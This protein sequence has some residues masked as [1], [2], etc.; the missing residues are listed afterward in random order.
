MIE[1]TT[2]IRALIDKAAVVVHFASMSFHASASV[3]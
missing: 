1:I 2:E 3:L